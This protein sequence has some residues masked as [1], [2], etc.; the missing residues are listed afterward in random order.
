M[1]WAKN[2][3]I[4]SST[5]D[6]TTTLTFTADT[7]FNTL[8]THSI[9]QTSWAQFQGQL[10]GDTGTNYAS[11]YSI[12]G[13]ADGTETSNANMYQD[14]VAGLSDQ[15]KIMYLINISAEEKL[16]IGFMIS[17]STAGAGTAPSRT[18]FVNK[19][20]TTGQQASSF[21]QVRDLGTGT[22]TTDSNLSALGTD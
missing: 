2:G 3:T 21:S 16:V 1:A 4:D 15:F 8:M 14:G 22:L 6:T 17:R 20:V 18:E 7:V 10:N 12:N 13:G 19:W 11:R 9:I 5:A